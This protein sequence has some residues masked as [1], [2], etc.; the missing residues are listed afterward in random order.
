M[1]IYTTAD[2]EIFDPEAIERR[3]RELGERWADTDAAA[4]LLETTEKSLLA[5]IILYYRSQDVAKSDA[6]LER[7]ARASPQFKKHQKDMVEARRIA[8][9]ARVGYD[10]FK[11]RCEM[12]RTRMAT[13]RAQM[14]MR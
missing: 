8:T 7:H 13:E 6:A 1:T 5:E 2:G 10:A 3:L 11:V 4:S 9:R 12:E 14:Q